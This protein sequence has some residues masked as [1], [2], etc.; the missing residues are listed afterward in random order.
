MVMSGRSLHTQWNDE[1]GKDD[2]KKYDNKKLSD[3]RNDNRNLHSYIQKKG[4]DYYDDATKNMIKSTNRYTDDELRQ[5]ALKYN[6]KKDFKLG[7]PSHYI[8]SKERN[9]TKNL[10]TGE[11]RGTSD[12][13]HDIT[14]HMVPAGNNLSKR[15]IYAHEFYNENGKPVAAYVGLTNDSDVRYKEHMSGVNR[16]NKEIITPVT[17][18]IINNPTFKHVYKKLSD[19]VSS[20]DAVK[21]EHEWETNYK[22][23][24][25]VMLNVAKSGSLGGGGYFIIDDKS[26]KDVV[27]MAV[28]D[29]LTLKEFRE[30]Y[31]SVHNAIY[32]RKLY[33]EPYNYLDHFTRMK[34]TPVDDTM[35]KV[36]V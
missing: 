26:I 32:R 10:E 9:Y 1:M 30:K 5:E 16:L 17:K 36:K 24:G 22:N 21:L 29:G 20:L 12:F 25:W 4:R 34:R 28:D 6:T 23:E 27:K 3:F 35:K 15:M 19:Y 13:Y 31:P 8:S 33:L 2:V 14:S 11:Y 18:F 7:S